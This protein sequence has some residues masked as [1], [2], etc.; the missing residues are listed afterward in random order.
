MRE[1]ENVGKINMKLNTENRLLWYSD[2]KTARYIKTEFLEKNVSGFKAGL[3]TF[4]KVVY[5]ELD[6]TVYHYCDGG[7]LWKPKVP[8]GIASPHDVLAVKVSLLTKENYVSNLPPLV[9]SVAPRIGDPGHARLSSFTLNGNRLRIE[10]SQTPQLEGISDFV[11]EGRASKSIESNAGLTYLK[12][13]LTGFFGQVREMILSHNGHDAPNLG[14]TS[15]EKF[16]PVLMLSSDGVRLKVAYRGSAID[17]VNFATLYLKDPSVLYNLGDVVPCDFPRSMAP[18]VSGMKIEHVG[19]SRLLEERM[20]HEGSSYDHGRLGAE[21]AYKVTRD[22]L[23]LGDVVLEEPS[24]GG[25]DLYTP[26]GKVVVQARFI[27]D[28][29]QFEPLSPNDA[30]RNQLEEL[31][32]KLHQDFDTNPAAAVGYVILSY[33]DACNLVKT[34]VMEMSRVAT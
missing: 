17:E 4:L 29:D 14:I 27:K 11:I 19:F 10:V 3:P 30:L 22:K 28:F 18:I 13:E 31:A 23:G 25:K 9:L 2:R 1:E 15:G 24:K 5:L 12:F 33:L 26:D 20:L 8:R 32:T 6:T 34:L 16:R 21:I 7:K